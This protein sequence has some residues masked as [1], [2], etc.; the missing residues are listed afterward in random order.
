MM[1]QTMSLPHREQGWLGGCIER[2]NALNDSIQTKKIQDARALVIAA[3][4]TQSTKTANASVAAS[5]AVADSIYVAVAAPESIL[6]THGLTILAIFIDTC[7]KGNATTFLT[8]YKASTKSRKDLAKAL[9]REACRYATAPAVRLAGPAPVDN[10]ITLAD[11]RREREAEEAAAAEALRI[12]T[13]VPPALTPHMTKAYEMGMA[14]ESLRLSADLDDQE[15]LESG[16]KLA[17]KFHWRR[18]FVLLAQEVTLIHKEHLEQCIDRHVNF[19]FCFDEADAEYRAL[20]LSGVPEDANA[21]AVLKAKRARD[22]ESWSNINALERGV[23]ASYR[24]CQMKALM[25]AGLHILMRKWWKQAPKTAPRVK[26][27]VRLTTAEKAAATASMIRKLKANEITAKVIVP[28]KPVEQIHTI[29]IK[30]LPEVNRVTS[31]DLNSAIRRLVARY[32]GEV[33]TGIGGV[34]IPMAGHASKGF[35]FVELVS[36]ENARRTLEAMGVSVELEFGGVVSELAPT[37]ALSNRKTKEEMEAEK[38]KVAA[39]KRAAES[40]DSVSAAIKTAMRGP[41]GE[42]K[43]IC[44]AEIKREKMSAAEQALKD[45]IAAAF[46]TL[47]DAPTAAAKQFEVSFA[48]AAA[49]PLPEKVEVIDPFQIKVAGVEYALVAAPTTVI[50]KAQMALR[51]A[52]ADALAVEER[53]AARSAKRSEMVEDATSHWLVERETE[54]KVVVAEKKEEVVYKSFQEAFKARLAAAAAKK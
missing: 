7:G 14:A 16:R 10:T 39:E 43:P 51:Q 32:G 13:F 12:A 49:K 3:G 29:V 28:I 18:I 5:V 8:E 4:L 31:R 15:L 53:R 26:K 6:N 54:V 19:Q 21:A 35:C 47:S 17:I 34:Y 42:L 27:H 38:A 25:I 1:Q 20:W 22:T 52:A 23:V 11:I 50:G 48:A 40:V 2:W 36:A 46:P 41:G 9:V 45:R 33:R 30:N 37:L 24:R 44:L